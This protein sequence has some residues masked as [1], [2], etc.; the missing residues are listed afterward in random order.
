VRFSIWAQVVLLAALALAVGCGKPQEQSAAGEVTGYVCTTC[1]AK[2]QVEQA[3]VADFC[4]QCKGTDLQ[5]VIGYVCATDGHLTLN[6]RRSKPIPCEQC[7]VQTS[8]IRQPT[9]AELEAWGA[10]KKSRTEV[11]R[12]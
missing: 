4:P 5:P 9:A 10:A 7:G 12:K 3:V 1:K 2:F 8:S 6:T 11:C